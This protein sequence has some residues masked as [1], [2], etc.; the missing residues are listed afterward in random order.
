MKRIETREIEL[1]AIVPHPHNREFPTCGEEWLAFAE[2]V[3]ENGI[4]EPLVVRRKSAECRVIS[5][6]C[7][8]WECIQGHRRRL[9]GI[10]GGIAAAMCVV[11]ECDDE[12]AFREMWRGNV[13][14]LNP[15]PVD[16]AKFVRGMMD[17]Y[18]ATVETLAAEM[19]R[20]L[21][22][23]RTRQRLLDLGDEVCEAV[24]RPDKERL[25][26]GAVEEI[27]KVP[28]AWWP[29]AVQLVLHPDLDLGTLNAEQ[30]RDVLHTCLLEPRARAEAW[31]G[32]REK[33]QKTWRKDLEKHCLKGTKDELAVQVRTLAE[34]ERLKSGFEDAEGMVPLEMVLPGAPEKLRWL[35][36]AVKHGLAVQVVPAE[37]SGQRAAASGKRREMDSRAVVDG[38][39]LREAES[40]AAEHGGKAWLV[41]GRKKTVEERVERAKSLAEGEGD[42]MH[43][44]K[45]EVAELIEQTMQ[46]AAMIDMGLVKKLAMWAVSADADPAT[47][48]E[49]VPQWAIECAYEGN[50]SRID[51][52]V[53]WVKSIKK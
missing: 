27:L 14:R 23:V 12:E 28:E 7:E 53:N 31:E 33:L 16:E 41:T 19:K 38:V 50:W 3:A 45:D 35:H 24:R 8:E 11:V 43:H 42:P 26:M 6:Q 37:G 40:A 29:E 20:S 34:A 17:F 15:D 36:L 44:T 52:V 13:H 21:E 51:A 1:S 39:L 4:L 30:A 32:M 47:A 18:G 48:P 46:H 10:E 2:D 22:W 25:T 9:A 49:W 5:D